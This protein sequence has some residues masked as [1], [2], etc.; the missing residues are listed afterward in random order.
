MAVIGSDEWLSELVTAAAEVRTTQDASGSDCGH[1]GGLAG[2]QDRL[3][4][5]PLNTAS[6]SRP[7]A[8]RQR[9][10]TLF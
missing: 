1:G 4:R 2:R 3:D 8:R 10:P 9:V 7:Q 6:R 5:R